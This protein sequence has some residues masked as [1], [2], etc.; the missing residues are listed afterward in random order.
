M[1]APALG[2]AVIGL[3]GRCLRAGLDHLA[4]VG[5]HAR[6]V[7]RRL[8]ARPDSELDFTVFAGSRWRCGVGEAMGLEAD[9]P[10]R[11]ASTG[12]PGRLVEAAGGRF[13]WPPFERFTGDVDLFHGPDYFLPPHRCPRRLYTV[14]DLAVLRRPE[15]VSD[16][17]R[18]YFEKQLPS[19]R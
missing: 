18:R 5:V 19:W 14:H 3:D 9:A 17:F 1:A 16:D 8:L 10:A 15:F 13:A 6:E 4:G 7:F 2:R 12:L 11:L